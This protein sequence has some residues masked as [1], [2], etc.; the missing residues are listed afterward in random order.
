MGRSLAEIPTSDSLLSYKARFTPSSGR[1][2]QDVKR[3][4][5]KALSPLLALP[6][7]VVVPHGRSLGRRAI[8]GCGA[9]PAAGGDHARAAPLRVGPPAPGWSS[10]RVAPRPAGRRLATRWNASPV[11]G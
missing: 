4:R 11:A 6:R 7:R 9:F 5:L 10:H 8:R 3:S 2:R 1:A